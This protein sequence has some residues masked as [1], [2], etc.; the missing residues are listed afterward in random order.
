LG[1]VL[2]CASEDEEPNGPKLTAQGL[3]APCNH[4]SIVAP[5]ETPHA[6]Y[7]ALSCDSLICVFA[8]DPVIPDVECSGDEDCNADSLERFECVIGQADT[9]GSCRLA[10]DYVLDR[11]HCAKRCEDDSD[12]EPSVM[13]TT[14]E[15]GFTC[16]RVPIPGDPCCRKV[17]VCADEFVPDEQLDAS[18]KAG[19]EEGCCAVDGQPVEPAPYGCG[20]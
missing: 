1:L 20:Q 11:S 7:P 18:C 3:G 19:T 6:S 5:D 9:T 16:G 15:S 2:A 12:C 13:K 14:C 4:G 8:E 17:C 10:L